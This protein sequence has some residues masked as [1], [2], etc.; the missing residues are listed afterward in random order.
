MSDNELNEQSEH[1]YWH[2]IKREREALLAV[3]RA[4]KEYYAQSV[5]RE[6]Y[7]KNATVDAK[8]YEALEALPPELKA[9]IE[10]K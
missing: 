3:A 8:L 9:E 10:K 4:A 6:I 5:I 1:D 7:G 2:K